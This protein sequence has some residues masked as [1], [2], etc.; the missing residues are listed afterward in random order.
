MTVLGV[1]PRGGGG[2]GP[3]TK[4]K[5]RLNSGRGRCTKA[6]EKVGVATTPEN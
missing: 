6:R 2:K 4:K 3:G 1:E 5:R